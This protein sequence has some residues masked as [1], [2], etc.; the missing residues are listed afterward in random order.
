VALKVLKAK[1]WQSS[2]ERGD[3]ILKN[4]IVTIKLEKVNAD[5]PGWYKL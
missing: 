4:I 3:A 2:N 5:H 1:M